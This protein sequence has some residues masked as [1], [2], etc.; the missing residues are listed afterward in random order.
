MISIDATFPSFC[1]ACRVVSLV[2]YNDPR[3]V[4]TMNEPVS[5]HAA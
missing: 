4:A 2:G 1:A 5:Y 3:G